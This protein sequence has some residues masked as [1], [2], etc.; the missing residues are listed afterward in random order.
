AARSPWESAIIAVCTAA[1]CAACNPP[2]ALAFPALLDRLACLDPALDALGH[3]EDARVPQFERSSGGLVR[4]QAHLVVAIE[5][6]RTVG[7]CR[8]VSL[9]QSVEVHPFRAGNVTPR[10]PVPAVGVEDAGRAFR[11]QRRGLLDGE[12]TE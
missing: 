2:P 3:D 1:R 10:P 8:K 6:Q 11:Q 5:Y 12:L 7:R 9:G 4:G